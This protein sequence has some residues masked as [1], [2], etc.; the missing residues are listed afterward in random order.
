MATFNIQNRQVG[1]AGHTRETRRSSDANAAIIKVTNTGSIAF[2]EEN[3]EE[4]GASIARFKS[5]SLSRKKSSRN[6]D[7]RKA[8]KDY[9]E[10]IKKIPDLKDA[11]LKQLAQDLLSV[12]KDLRDADISSSLKKQGF[13][14][15]SHAYLA[16]RHAKDAMVSDLNKF[17]FSQ[18]IQAIELYTSRIESVETFL[19]GHMEKFGEDIFAGINSGEEQAEFSKLGLGTPQILRDYYRSII[20]EHKSVLDIYKDVVSKH[21]VGNFDTRCDFLMKFVSR[22]LECAKGKYDS[23]KLQLMHKEIHLLR[24]VQSEIDR[25]GSY[26]GQ[27]DAKKAGVPFQHKVFEQ[28]VSM[29]EAVSVREA[30][31]SGL[32]SLC[33]V[34][35][36]IKK[37][38]VVNNL[39]ACISDMPDTL[40]TNTTSRI[41]IRMMIYAISE[42]LQAA[43][44]ET[45]EELAK[46]DLYFKAGGFKSDAADPALES[47]K[48][49]AYY[50]ERVA[51]EKDSAVIQSQEAA[52]A[53]AA[54]AEAEAGAAQAGAF[55]PDAG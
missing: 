18:N 37:I 42:K 39:V 4:I 10:Q 5:S 41:K 43:A 22:H 44:G 15:P 8:Q 20:K 14:D 17:S 2:I 28:V 25:V 40:F 48:I 27:Y 12:G 6:D 3:K 31:V 26:F 21:G 19:Q 7:A 54:A 24:S 29:V 35:D 9:V 32:H 36:P 16:L 34:K 30:Q 38:S 23:V 13:T 11:G 1:G 53:A 50:P 45:I 49:A 55:Y 51:A 33:G 46:S 52:A 47:L